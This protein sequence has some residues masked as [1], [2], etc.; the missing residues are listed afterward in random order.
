MQGGGNG[1]R[2]KRFEKV[3]T[4]GSHRCQ[5]KGAPVQ[6]V[7]EK[8]VHSSIL[9][10]HNCRKGKKNLSY[11][12]LIETPEAGHRPHCLAIQLRASDQGGAPPKK[13]SEFN[14]V[15]RNKSTGGYVGEGRCQ[16][17]DMARAWAVEVR[18]AKKLEGET[19]V[20]GRGGEAGRYARG[21]TRGSHAKARTQ[22]QKK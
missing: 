15:R 5:K 1:S 12:A 22:L 14:S 19:E 2:A 20:I 3:E 21:K 18:R 7:P 6:S 13:R 17:S 10:Y 8:I 11:P 4:S 9:I 16:G